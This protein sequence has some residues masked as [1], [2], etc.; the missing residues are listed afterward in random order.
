MD[1]VHD[2]CAAINFVCFLIFLASVLVMT[3]LPGGGHRAH[4]WPRRIGF[5]AARC[6]P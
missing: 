5:N 6:L 4:R 2:Y 3:S 1:N